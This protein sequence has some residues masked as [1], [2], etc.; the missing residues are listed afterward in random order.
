[1]EKQ[2]FFTDEMIQGVAVVTLESELSNYQGD[3]FLSA[4]QELGEKY[5]RDGTN[6]A[7][8][9]FSRVKFFGSSVLEG[10]RLLWKELGAGEGHVS[11]CSLNEVCD[12]I[13]HLSH[14]DHVWTVY[15]DRQA[16]LT[17][18]SAPHNNG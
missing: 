12:Q 2:K 6:V 4:I 13:I 7:L 11:L 14:F 5:A 1:M 9:D 16:A 15:P 17:E 8:V 18:L 3:A 10:L